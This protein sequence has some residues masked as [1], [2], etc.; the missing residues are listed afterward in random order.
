MGTKNILVVVAHPDDEVLGLGA[1]LCIHRDKGHKISILILGNGEDSR[2][3]EFSNVSKR[4]KQA[5]KVADKLKAKLF[6]EDFPDNAFD[7]VP[8][9]NIT[10]KVEKIIDMVRPDLIYTHYSDDLN[11]DHRLTFQ[12]VMTA[13][14]PLS[15]SSV[16]KIIS[17][18]TLSSTEW[19]TKG[20][21][22]FAP[23]YYVDIS[24]YLKKKKEIIASYSGEMRG[25]PHSRSLEGVEILATYRGIESGLKFAEAFEIIR[26]IE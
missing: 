7:S 3:I 12:S 22:Q 6:I 21:K 18:E 14:R 2:G 24:K 10:K 20:H 25:Y 8:L 9:L 11:I 23:N 26:I 19:Q 16:K 13:A 5:N 1:T 17:F 15:G 4:L